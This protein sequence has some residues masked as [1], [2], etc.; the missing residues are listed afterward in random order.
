MA[1]TNTDV[2]ASEEPKALP[3]SRSYFE[4]LQRLTESQKHRLL[5]GMISYAFQGLIPDFSDD[6]LLDVSWLAIE[7]NITASLKKSM[8]GST[9]GRPRKKDASKARNRGRTK[10]DVKTTSK[11]SDTPSPIHSYSDSSPL[12]SSPYPRH[13]EEEF[14]EIELF[15]HDL[16]F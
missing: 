10:K 14:D 16:P 13:E 9:G 7:P 3:K 11:E 1:D 4:I 15:E 12:N 2:T 6:V 5:D 8:E